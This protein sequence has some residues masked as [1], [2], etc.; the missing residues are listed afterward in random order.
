VIESLE[1]EIQTQKIQI[2]SI[3]NYSS[4][5]ILPMI[6]LRDQKIVYFL[7]DYFKNNF[8]SFNFISFFNKE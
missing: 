1:Q 4:I 7:K 5:S 2:D 8:L 3:Q 6:H